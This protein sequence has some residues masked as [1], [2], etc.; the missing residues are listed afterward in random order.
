[1]YQIETFVCSVLP[2]SRAFSAPIIHCDDI[3]A[4]KSVFKDNLIRAVKS[5]GYDFGEFHV[6]M[7]ITL[8]E[9]YVDG[10]ECWCIIDTEHNTI[11][12]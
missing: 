3:L 12:Y 8:F 9:E 5:N 1:M 11:E 6:E 4:G 7:F 10:D 2:F